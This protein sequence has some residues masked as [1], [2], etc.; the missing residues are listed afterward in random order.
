MG[1]GSGGA[2]A[3][4]RAATDLAANHAG[5]P[6]GL[7]IDAFSTAAGSAKVP[8]GVNRHTLFDKAAP[9]D[10]QARQLMSNLGGRV[11]PPMLQNIPALATGDMSPLLGALGGTTYTRPGVVQSKQTNMLR[12]GMMSAIH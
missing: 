10:V 6:A 4:L 8:G 7:A 11:V 5:L 3:N 9:G 12:A 2:G 1:A